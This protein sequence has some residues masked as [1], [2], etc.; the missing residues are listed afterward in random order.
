[1]GPRVQLLCGE[2]LRIEQRGCENGGQCGTGC[3]AVAEWEAGAANLREQATFHTDRRAWS[4]GREDARRSATVWRASASRCISSLVH[5][6]SDSSPLTTGAHSTLFALRSQELV[7][8]KT[9]DLEPMPLPIAAATTPPSSRILE[10]QPMTQHGVAGE[11]LQA[12]REQRAA[13]GR[14][15]R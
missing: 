5:S 10:A 12:Y 8:A 13:E 7:D 4:S 3:A 11:R 9:L 15:V 1:M 6:F 14:P 2:R